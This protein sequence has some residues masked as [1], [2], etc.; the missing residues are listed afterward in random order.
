MPKP[1]RKAPTSNTASLAQMCVGLGFEIASEMPEYFSA[2]DFD[3]F[4]MCIAELAERLHRRFPADRSLCDWYVVLETAATSLWS[5]VKHNKSTKEWEMAALDYDTIAD[6]A[7]AAGV[8]FAKDTTP[9][10]LA[11]TPVAATAPGSMPWHG[12]LSALE[13][14]HKLLVVAYTKQD[15][16]RVAKRT[17]TDE[18]WATVRRRFQKHSLDIVGSAFEDQVQD[19]D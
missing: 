9:P 12:P 17:L 11:S 6:D 2:S 1:V 15:A 19:I 10:A 16:D 4:T 14:D 18:E 7:I 8:R 5:H 3:D 13:H